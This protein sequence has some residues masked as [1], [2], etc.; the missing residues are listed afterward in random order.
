MKGIFFRLTGSREVMD[1]SVMWASWQQSCVRQKDV[2]PWRNWPIHWEAIRSKRSMM[3]SC[4][5]RDSLAWKASAHWEQL[6]NREN[7][8]SNRW[9]TRSLRFISQLLECSFKRSFRWI[10]LF[11]S[12]S[13]SPLRPSRIIWPGVK[14]TSPPHGVSAKRSWNRSNV[15]SVCFNTKEYQNLSN[16]WGKK[17]F[18]FSKEIPEK[19]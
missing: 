8:S 16:E 13:K 2:A 17:T 11:S 3:R 15:I 14:R 4:W 10:R 5:V 6:W 19:F 18:F 7:I 12:F 9:L 1:S